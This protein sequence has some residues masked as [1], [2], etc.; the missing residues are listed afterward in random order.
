MNADRSGKKDKPA[1]LAL[2]RTTRLQWK[3]G[4]IIEAG[5]LK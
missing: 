1:F 4:N 2:E 3:V 5:D